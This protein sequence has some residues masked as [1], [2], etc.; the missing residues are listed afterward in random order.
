MQSE[1]MH[2]I[3]KIIYSMHFEARYPAN[4]VENP[5]R[6]RLPARALLE[7]GY[8][9]VEPS[10]ASQEEIRKVS[11]PAAHRDGQIEKPIRCLRPRRMRCHLRRR[12]GAAGRAR[13][14]TRA[15]ARSPRR[16]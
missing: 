8:E 13:L 2:I 10:P 16:S 11:R 4:P 6:A 3:V 1:D 14:R 15:P 7:A 5:D 12:A 9:F